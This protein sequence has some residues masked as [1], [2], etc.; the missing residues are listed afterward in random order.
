MKMIRRYN[1]Q[2]GAW[3]VGYWVGTRFYVV[4]VVRDLAA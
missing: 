4:K 3:E 2:F 1:L